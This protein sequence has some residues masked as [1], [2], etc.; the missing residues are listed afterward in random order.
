MPNLESYINGIKDKYLY[1]AYNNYDMSEDPSEMS[2]MNKE[3]EKSRFSEEDIKNESSSRDKISIIIK[4]CEYCQKEIQINPEIKKVNTG[5]ENININEEIKKNEGNVNNNNK[6]YFECKNKKC[7]AV[8]CSEKHRD[9]DF[10]TFHFFHCKLKIF[11]VDY[12]YT[13]QI[14]FFNDLIILLN[15]IIKY[16]FSNITGKDDYLFFLPFIKIITFLLKNLNMR[17]LSDMVIEFSQKNN[18]KENELYELLFYQEVIFYYYNLIILSLNFGVRCNLLEFAKKELDFLA[19]DEEQFFN[20][21]SLT[22][23]IFNRNTHFYQE[24]ID[25]VH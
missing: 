2:E 10:K 6:K 25:F 14:T 13:E 20:K 21:S 12:N 4:K 23:T 22:S 17:Y 5:D 18:I 7:T 11:F 16:I 19:E 3:T 9:L 24:Y 15:D 1:D 8:Y